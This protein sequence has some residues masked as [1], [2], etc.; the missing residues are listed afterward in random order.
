MLS[1]R[2]S[3]PADS[4]PRRRSATHSLGLTAVVVLALSLTG[5]VAAPEHEAGSEPQPWSVDV[6]DTAAPIGGT[7]ARIR[8]FD[9][10]VE[11]LQGA[12]QI[13]DE[14]TINTPVAPGDVIRTADDSVVEIQLADGTLVRLDEYTRLSVVTLADEQTEYENRTL[15]GLDEGTLSVQVGPLDPETKIIRVD[16]EAATIFFLEEGLF[17]IDVNAG[18]G[19]R[20]TSKRGVAEILA[21]NTSTLV[22]SGEMSFVAPGYAAEG[23]RVVSTRPR[24][25]FDRYVEERRLA[26]L[27]HSRG[28]TYARYEDE[29]PEP[30]RPYLVEMDAYG[31]WQEHPDYGVIW[32]PRVA[33][34]WRPYYRGHWAY[35]PVGWVWVSSDPWGYAPYHYG[36]WEYLDGYGWS[37]LPG[38]VYAPAWVS[39]GYAGD[40]IGWSPLG[41]YDAPSGWSISIGFGAFHASYWSFVDYGHFHDHNVSTVIIKEEHIISHDVHYAARPPAVRLRDIRERRQRQI[42]RRAAAEATPRSQVTRS[43]VAD[44]R[45]DRGFRRREAAL[46]AASR[47]S[48]G[49]Q[50]P[51]DQAAAAPDSPSARVNRTLP[52]RTRPTGTT[53]EATPLR[54]TPTVTRDRT[55]RPTTV[56]GRSAAPSRTRDATGTRARPEASAGQNRSR[57]TREPGRTPSRTPTRRTVGEREP[58]RLL[59]GTRVRRVPSPSRDS[60][61][62]SDRRSGTVRQRRAP[63][64]TRTAPPSRTTPRESSSRTDTVRERRTPR[65]TRTTPP[66]RT[67]P[68]KSSARPDTVRERRTPR[69]T[70]T[71]PPS[72][73]T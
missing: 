57:V 38:A 15:L 48:R 35:R 49:V 67:T 7:Y 24:D 69:S 37:W 30:V 73:T 45:R 60:S 20:V 25:D 70:R 11:L 65:S 59:T 18:G 23:P 14:V 12:G 46:L 52:G 43:R 44:G 56:R 34:G 53:R 51:A 54:R 21:Q 10:S 9:G 64:T 32:T 71:T 17:R 4:L 36:R 29:L 61:T 13:E 66:S 72:R 26:Y 41:Y 5:S 16:T 8:Q 2:T 28:R 31:A 50:P 63:A 27:G 39:F 6:A 42:F 19:T 58:R 1:I 55:R 47:R 3:I 62:T 40:Y 33:V 68:K 22:R